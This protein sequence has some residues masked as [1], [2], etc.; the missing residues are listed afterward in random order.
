MA[1]LVEAP[2][3]IVLEFARAEATGDPHAFRFAPQSY[4]VRTPRGGFGSSELQWDH[5]LLGRLEA[6]RR[7]GQ[8]PALLVEVGETLRRFLAPT[9]WEL[10]E[11]Q[12]SAALRQRRPVHI[13]IRSAAA[14]LFALPWEL[15]TLRATGQSLG[16]LPGVLVHYEWPETA[17][18]PSPAGESGGRLLVAWSA[19]G[20]ALPA[21]EHVE[22][23][24]EAALAGV[25]AFDPG[26]DVL[27]HASPGRLAA[28]LAEA[29]GTS[30]PIAAL[31]LL[32]HGGSHGSNFGLVLDGDE[33]GDPPALLDPARL[34]QLL[35]PHAATLRLVVL[36][37]CDSG[38]Q[39]DLGGRLGSA[40]QRLHRAGLAAVVASR[41]PLSVAGSTR[42]TTTF[43]RRLLADHLPVELAF[44]A[45]RTAL[46]SHTQSLDWASVQLYSRTADGVHNY[47]FAPPPKE[48]AVVVPASVSPGEELAPSIAE[49]AGRGG[50][51]RWVGAL[52][53]L[54]G[55][56]ALLALVISR[57]L[58]G[59][60]VEANGALASSA[61]AP[62]AAAPTSAATST[63]AVASEDQ[64][65]GE[66]VT[67]ERLV[68]QPLPEV[69]ATSEAGGGDVPPRKTKKTTVAA[70][71]SVECSSGVKSYVR[72]LLPPGGGP[73]VRLV[74][75]ASPAGALTAGGDTPAAE[76]AQKRLRGA[77]AAKVQ[78][79][80]GDG[81]P[82][83]F[84]YEWAQ[85]G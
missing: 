27:T 52:A 45:A 85:S 36:A 49:P 82:C 40:A 10:H 42:L 76:A 16:G 81:L 58:T 23:I 24:R 48:D 7:P 2:L 54:L 62:P 61:A 11:E 22:A 3:E 20:G 51:R 28:A 71:A 14:E 4:I 6:I 26:T 9:G 79:H 57:V 84:K 77:A 44:V 63:S 8:D 70:K 65:E 35:A 46:T 83:H 13:T 15:L 30:R 66:I 78:Q 31:H 12:L 59:D 18:I 68:P 25:I 55:L 69:A 37:A 67:K 33:P 47:P 80:A 53:G 64:G 72:T 75:K 32:C 50:S 43:Y 39:G 29:E 73:V 60:G 19:A 5:Q 56:A 1:S 34:Q 17:T 74:I 38:N 21:A 41:Y